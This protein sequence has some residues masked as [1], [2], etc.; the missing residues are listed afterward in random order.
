MPPSKETDCERVVLEAAAVSTGDEGPADVPAQILV[1]P[2]GEVKTTAGAFVVDE[3][4]GEATVAAFTRHGTDL[5]IDYEHQ[6]LGGTYS[7]PSGLAPA[8]GWIKCLRLVTPEAAALAGVEPGLW[9]DVSWTGDARAR[10]AAREYRY[11]SPV[12]LV[13]RGDRRLMALHSVALTNKPAIIG[14]RPVVSRSE[15][16]AIAASAAGMDRPAGTEG[17]LAPPAVPAGEAGETFIFDGAAAAANNLALI[18]LREVL[19]LAPDAGAGTV[20]LAALSRIRSLENLARERAAE[21]RVARASGAGKLSPAQR[22]WA[23]ALAR[24]DPEEFDRWEALAPCVV[25]VG[26]IAPP[27]GAG[28]GAAGGRHAAGDVKNRAAIEAARREWR[29]NRAIL[30]KLCTED[31]YAAHAAR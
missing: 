7:S 10:L 5:P 16:V 24:R 8:A 13:R 20:L 11:L 17:D 18:T 6:T 21:D 9:A 30:E 27:A 1:A 15:A 22:D 19:S 29:A 26:R 2:W 14:M 31:A 4:A 28:P 12:A 25:L 23:L 3:T